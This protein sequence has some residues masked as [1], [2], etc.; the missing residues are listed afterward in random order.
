MLSV[1]EQPDMLRALGRKL[2]EQQAQNIDITLHEAFLAVTWDPPFGAPQ[3]RSLQDVDLG[4]LRAEAKALRQGI[5]TARGPLA[6]MFR[7]LGQEL[8]RDQVE[9]TSIVEEADGFR[10]SGAANGRYF[11]QLY[12]KAELLH[13]NTKRRST[14]G[15]RGALTLN[16]RLSGA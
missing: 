7:T 2:D 5:N 3:Q 14:R 1:S 15:G 9:A 10:V 13:L 16:G 12:R 8:T 4:S 6:E 11:R